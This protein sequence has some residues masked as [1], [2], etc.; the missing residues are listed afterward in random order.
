MEVR[1]RN[2][3]I[4][5]LSFGL[6]GLLLL[7]QVPLPVH[8]GGPCPVEDCD[9]EEGICRCDH[10]MQREAARKARQADRPV[11]YPCS[12]VGSHGPAVL[13]LDRT[14]IPERAELAS[15]RPARFVFVSPPPLPSRDLVFRLL[16]PP[17]V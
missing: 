17:R 1:T 6:I 11:V 16:R 9:C 12:D 10:W 3:A 7:Q 13:T 5:A 2:A 14:L 4:Y 8:I 15:P